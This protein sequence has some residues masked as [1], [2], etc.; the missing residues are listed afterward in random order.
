ME[1][2]ISFLLLVLG[3]TMTS[4]VRAGIFSCF[5]PRGRP[6][7]DGMRPEEL[8]LWSSPVKLEPDSVIYAFNRPAVA[9]GVH[10]GH[11]TMTGLQEN[12]GCIVT[13]TE[14]EIPARPNEGSPQQPNE[15]SLQH[16]SSSEGSTQQPNEESP[17]P[18]G[19]GSPPPLNDESPPHPHQQ[20]HHQLGEGS[21]P[22]PNGASP[23]HSNEESTQLPREGSPPH[24]NGAS[25]RHP[26]EEPSQLSRE[27]SPHRPDEAAPDHL[28]EAAPH[29]PN[30]GLPQPPTDASSSDSD[31]AEDPLPMVFMDD[32]K[33]GQVT[34]LN[35]PSTKPL[36]LDLYIPIHSR[37]EK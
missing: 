25:P 10:R 27:G 24:S 35:V 7:W 31:G 11:W 14:P 30:E 36:Q 4:D 1:T 23:R 20:V 16:Q 22:L 33:Y 15:E 5:R 8:S 9:I 21:P 6:D 32:L 19:E 13:H 28:N 37:P 17:Q 18:T 29:H 26:N 34:Y 3:T 12:L 2:H